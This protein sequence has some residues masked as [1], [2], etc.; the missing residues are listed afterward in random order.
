MFHWVEFPYP[1]SIQNDFVKD[2][3]IQKINIA[4]KSSLFRGERASS[5]CPLG[6]RFIEARGDMHNCSTSVYSVM[7][8]SEAVYPLV[9]KTYE[10]FQQKIG[11][12]Y[13]E[14]PI[15]DS[16]GLYAI[17]DTRVH[18]LPYR[19]ILDILVKILNDQTYPYIRLTFQRVIQSSIAPISAFLLAKDVCWSVSPFSFVDSNTVEWF[20]KTKEYMR[21][22]LES[23]FEHAIWNTIRAKAS[24]PCEYKDTTVY[25]PL[26][27]MRPQMSMAETIH[28][29]ERGIGPKKKV[30]RLFKE[31]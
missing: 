4:F 20:A 12:T 14:L 21:S 11:T 3:C 30:K 17:N 25:N 9:H 26:Q 18:I 2:Y 23:K 28:K 31:I 6:I 13:S 8:Y 1:S 16:V 27:T 22:I 7:R 15:G 19:N 24:F 10:D 5:V 29:L